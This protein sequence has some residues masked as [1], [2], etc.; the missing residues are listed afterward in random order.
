VRHLMEQNNL[1]L[2]LLSI[3]IASRNRV[4]CAISA[5][6]SILEIPDPRLELVVQDN[7]DSRE[8][9][10]YVHDNIEDNRLRYRY[11]PPPF[12]SIDNF[13]AAVELATGEY[14]C[15]IGDDDGVNPE[16]LEAAAWA[17]AN[18]LDALTSRN[19][20]IYRWPNT[21]IS[22]TL[23]TKVK[24]G[25]LFISKFTGE[26]YEVAV[27]HE[28]SKLVRN[29]GV[30]YLSFHLPKL[31]HGLVRLSCMD[32]IQRKIGA[33]FGGLSPDIFSAMAISEVANRV[34]FIDYP[35]TIPGACRAALNTHSGGIRR[36]EKAPH[37][38]DRGEYRWCEL[39]PRVYT[40][41]TIWVDSGVAALRAM[42]RDDLVQELNLP[43][44]AAYCIG[45]NRGITG[46]VLRDLF[47]G[48]RIVRRNPA[49]GAIHFA[50]SLLTGPS[51]KFA[52][53]VWN[54]FLMIIGTRGVYRI[55]GLVN[56]VEAS[57]ALTRYLKENGRSFARCALLHD[58]SIACSKR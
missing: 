55:D 13:N 12:S 18:D 3:V 47:A 33:Y 2:P 36:L 58:R 45:A 10:S 38:R 5:I 30:Y 17:K 16:I 14:V 4:P 52:G 53:R 29:G 25:E 46:P 32:D 6:Q 44:L 57:H 19:M 21:G 27:K 24:G 50:W 37:F 31:Y 54:R 42:G 48:M 35:L 22:S 40:T 9:E 15:L 49:I 1:P 8:L 23:F 28:V 20:L 34:M 43:K 39:V 26:I 7:S 41:E 51:A 56:M 11:T